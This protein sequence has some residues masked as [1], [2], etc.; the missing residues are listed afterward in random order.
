ML[1]GACQRT[2]L[3]RPELMMLLMTWPR[4]TAF[5]SSIR[6]PPERA[7]TPKPFDLLVV[8]PELGAQHGVGVLTEQRRRRADAPR[9]LRQPHR[10]RD[11]PHL[12]RGGVVAFDEDVA[13]LHLR[14][15]D[16]AI[17]RVDGAH[18]DAGRHQERLP[19]LV[20]L[21]QEDF[22]KSRD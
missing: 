5:T 8:E 19:L 1:S 9:S 18:G 6:L 10:R 3:G 22:L 14:M 7:E 2:V 17:D 4:L 11:D 15:V 13:R 16:D 12:A 20:A 21:R